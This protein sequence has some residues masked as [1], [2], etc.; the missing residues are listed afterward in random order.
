TINGKKVGDQVLDP[1]WTDYSKRIL[2]STYDVNGFLNHGVNI[3]GIM[4][5]NGWFISPTGRRGFARPQFILQMN[6]EYEDG[7]KESLYSD[8]NKGWLASQGPILTNGIYTG[9]FY[10][11]RLEKPGWDTPDYD[12]STEMSS[13]FCP[14]TTDSPGGRMVPQNVEPIKILKEIKAVSV[15]EV[16]PIKNVIHP[17]RSVYVFDLGQNISGWV[18]LR[19]KGSKGTRVTM[20]YAEVLYDNGLV[21]QENLR[22]AVS[23]DE[24]ILKG[25]GI[26]TCFVIR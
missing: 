3:I 22:T 7:A 15:T 12:I 24:Y 25:K 14:L 1:G 23:T 21:N 26:N 8:N 9:E 10:D 6:I 16:K 5:G 19:L 4:L 13:W 11:A 2:Y 18:K 20:K 17:K